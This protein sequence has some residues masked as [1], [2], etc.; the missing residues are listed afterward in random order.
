MQDITI[1]FR[2]GEVKTFHCYEEPIQ[3]FGNHMTIYHYKGVDNISYSDIKQMSA[4]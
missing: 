2:N 1:T 4:A 3:F